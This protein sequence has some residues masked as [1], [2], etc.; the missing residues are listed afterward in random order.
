VNFIRY[1]IRSLSDNTNYAAIYTGSTYGPDANR[2]ELVR[3]E[4][5]FDE[6]VL[7]EELAAEYAVDLQLDVTAVTNGPTSEPQVAFVPKTATQF[8]SVTG[9]PTAGGRPQ[10]VRAIRARLS[11]RSREGDRD[12]NVDSTSRIAGNL[13]RVGLGADGGAPFARVRTLQA[14]VMLNNHARIQW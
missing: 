4:L 2:T 12:T 3:R 14:D 1:D 6:T 7:F 11:V 5:A 10:D 13:Y 9:A 8:A